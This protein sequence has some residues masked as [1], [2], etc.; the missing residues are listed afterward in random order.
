VHHITGFY[1]SVKTKGN[2]QGNNVL[3]SVYRKI[4]EEVHK[5]NNKPGEISD[6]KNAGVNRSS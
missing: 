5:R 4:T 2:L 6:D 3:F 1:K